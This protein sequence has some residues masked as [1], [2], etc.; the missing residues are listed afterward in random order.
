MSEVLDRLQNAGLTSLQTGMDTIRNVIGCPV[1]G[2]GRDE[3]LD[4]SPVAYQ[5]TSMFAG[6]RA[7]TNLP[8]KFNV[9]I[10]S[11]TLNCTH[12]E[13]QDLAL[14]PATR[15][16]DGTSAAGFNVLIGGK[17]G[18]GGYRIASPLDLFVQP[19]DAAEICAMITLIYR[20]HGPRE[21]RSLSRLTFLID[22]W[23]VERF[24]Q[25]LEQ[26]AGRSF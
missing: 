9:T 4:A 16:I 6:N 26:R 23:G 20:D 17:M 14:T 3:L 15:E 24:R 8:R 5:L 2:I 1:A 19:E 21:A 11:C 25:E 7:F 13:S 18:S 10:T 22:A 12:A